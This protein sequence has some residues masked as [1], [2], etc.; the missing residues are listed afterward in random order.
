MTKVTRVNMIEFN[1][2]TEMT[3]QQK[4]F[5]A[6]AASLFPE[7]ILLTSVQTGPTSVMSISVYPDKKSAD[8][9][10]ATRDKVF[11]DA[12]DTMSGWTLEGRVRHWSMPALIPII[13]ELKA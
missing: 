10:M 7:C 2:E 13:G 11:K 9:A 4:W 5:Q 8:Q 6:N 3:E 12:R 1:S